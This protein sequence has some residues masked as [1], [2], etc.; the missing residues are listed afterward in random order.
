MHARLF[1]YT[2]ARAHTHSLRIRTR[3]MVLR[4]KDLTSSIFM[5]KATGLTSLGTHL[6]VHTYMH[7]RIHK[8]R[9]K[10][11]AQM[12][13]ACFGY[14]ISYNCEF[15]C[16][17]LAIYCSVIFYRERAAEGNQRRNDSR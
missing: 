1:S 10:I 14:C 9:W 8:H 5:L 15:H 11:H 2:H 17:V 6:C 3:A 13:R 4:Q 7:T 12:M 16:I